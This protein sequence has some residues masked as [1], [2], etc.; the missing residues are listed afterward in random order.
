MLLMMLNFVLKWHQHMLAIPKATLGISSLSPRI[1][2]MKAAM[3]VNYFDNRIDSK[4]WKIWLIELTC[5][6]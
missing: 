2:S 3:N 4:L 1:T 6:Y 5:L